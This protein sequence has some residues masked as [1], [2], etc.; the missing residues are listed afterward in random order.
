[1]F[2]SEHTEF[3]AR[4]RDLGNAEDGWAGWQ[5]ISLQHPC[6]M[7][8]S[9]PEP[10]LAPS[11]LPKRNHMN[12]Q[13]TDIGNDGV[14]ARRNV[15][16]PKTSTSLLVHP[17]LSGSKSIKRVEIE[18]QR[19]ESQRSRETQGSTGGHEEDA[20]STCGGER[21]QAR[22]ILRVLG[23]KCRATGHRLLPASSQAPK[24]THGDKKYLE[25][26]TAAFSFQRFLKPLSLC[27]PP[28]PVTISIEGYNYVVSLI[29][30]LKQDLRG[31][32]GRFEEGGQIK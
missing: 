1:M 3:L 14:L 12:Q 16:F 15:I 32:N 4:R 30:C 26:I 18:S 2:T 31:F 17:F 23:T 28:K 24:E 11:S 22:V 27:F 6:H 13:A 25:M 19:N 10:G 8:G 20:T 21:G 29:A 9:N 7:T 5:K